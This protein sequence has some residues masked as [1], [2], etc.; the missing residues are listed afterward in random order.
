MFKVDFATHIFVQAVGHQAV[1]TR[2]IFAFLII[3]KASL[4]KKIIKALINLINDSKSKY[5]TR[6]LPVK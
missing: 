1:K 6:N 2:K 5:T 4:F 3:I